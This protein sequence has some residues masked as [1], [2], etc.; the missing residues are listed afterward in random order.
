VPSPTGRPVCSSRMISV[1]LAR[2]AEVEKNK[3]NKEVFCAQSFAISVAMIGSKGV[4]LLEYSFQPDTFEDHRLAAPRAVRQFGFV[5]W[6]P[7]QSLPRDTQTLRRSSPLIAPVTL[8]TWPDRMRSARTRPHTEPGSGVR[9]SARSGQSMALLLRRR[10]SLTQRHACLLDADRSKTRH[11]FARWA[12]I[13]GLGGKCTH[14]RSRDA[15]TPVN[16]ARAWRGAAIS[17]CDDVT[18]VRMVFPSHHRGGQ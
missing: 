12:V 4:G 8:S 1:S 10:S 18:R 13:P 5:A 16:V 15:E 17:F 14:S 7:L 9:I 6:Q 2:R 11:W 3:L